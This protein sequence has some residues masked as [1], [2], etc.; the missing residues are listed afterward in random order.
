MTE[1]A[2][3]QDNISEC[4]ETGCFRSEATGLAPGT[5]IRYTMKPG[6]TVR[7]SGSNRMFVTYASNVIVAYAVYGSSG[8]LIGERSMTMTE[9][10][11]GTEYVPSMEVVPNPE[12]EQA[13]QV[14][15]IMLHFSSEDKR[16]HKAASRLI[17]KG[18]EEEEVR[19]TLAFAYNV[20]LDDGQDSY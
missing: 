6:R 5:E 14:E 1:H 15:R 3:I 16:L 7:L 17:A 20:G 12:I 19:E 8:Y 13:R 10:L 2:C 9:F 18:L 4:I 11:Q